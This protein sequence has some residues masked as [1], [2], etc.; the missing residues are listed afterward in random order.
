MQVK[1]H[2]EMLLSTSS[3]KEVFPSMTGNWGT[4]KKAFTK[5]YEELN[6]AEKLNSSLFID[7]DEEQDYY[8]EDEY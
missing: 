3:L 8:E 5:A 6:E 7:F 4:D 1:N 2:Y